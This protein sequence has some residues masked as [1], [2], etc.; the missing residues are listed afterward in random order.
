VIA[1]GLG[2]IQVEIF[3]DVQFRMTPLTDRDATEMVREIKGYRL[4][5]GYRGNPPAD[6][7]AIENVLL[8]IPRLVEEIPE[9]IELDLNPIFALP[10]R[11]G[12]KIVDARI[13]VEKSSPA[14]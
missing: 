8:R 9:I 5:Q 4:L 2:G 14:G 12:C 7:K 6:I 1:F 13:R 11:Q 3:G 10:E